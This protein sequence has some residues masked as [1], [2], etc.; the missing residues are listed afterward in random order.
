VKDLPCATPAKERL[1]PLIL[2]KG[3]IYDF[4]SSVNAIAHLH[5]N[6]FISQALRR[7]DP[8]QKDVLGY[9]FR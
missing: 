9:T 2:R 1:M 7:L 3:D 6:M 8:L 5:G 4:G